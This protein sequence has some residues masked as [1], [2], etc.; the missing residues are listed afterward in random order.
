M[1]HLLLSAAIAALAAMAIAQSTDQASQPQGREGGKGEPPPRPL[2][3]P[4]GP[5]PCF[6][7]SDN[8]V[9]Q[10]GAKCPVFGLA[11]PGAEVTVSFAGQSASAKAGADGRWRVVLEPMEPSA[12]GREMKI[13]SAGR[14]VS[15]RNVRVGDVWL[16]FGQSNMDL[17]FDS[18]FSNPKDA[19]SDDAAGLW[20]MQPGTNKSG[21]PVLD[22][23]RTTSWPAQEHRVTNEWKPATAENARLFSM[24][25]YYFGRQ[26]AREQGVP[27]GMINVAVGTTVIGQWCSADADAE[28]RGSKAKPVTTTRYA[29][30][31]YEGKKGPICYNGLI[32]PLQGMALRGMLFYQG[33]SEAAWFF[34]ANYDKWF[35]AMI[36]DLRAKWG[37]GD[38]PLLFVQIQSGTGKNDAAIREMQTR[39]LGQPNTAMIVCADVCR[40]LHPANKQQVAERLV[41]AARV[42]AYDQKGEYMG[43]VFK[44]M[45]VQGG[46]AR[47]SFDHAGGGLIAKDGKPLGV[48][49]AEP[50]DVSSRSAPPAFLIA[51]ADGRFFA[52]A[53]EI[54]GDA[55]VVSNPS[56]PVPAAVRYAWHVNPAMTLYN[57]EGLP[58]SPF[59]TDADKPLD[60]KPPASKPAS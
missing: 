37:M 44:E 8:C 39:G 5:V 12:Q 38:L 23:H 2:A 48:A 18:K 3:L 49:A 56:V 43:P 25:G 14:S 30:D 31:A 59:R 50:Y 17:P 19:P 34:N 26:T 35:T 4:D 45:K 7:F 40:G 6:V 28:A 22:I 55:V 27:V 10:R 47:I 16:C 53:A 21:V 11:E 32:H 57:K 42:L 1:K 9:L 60:A 54:E 33:E 13:G 24:I 36:K 41:A 29:D 52:A 51:G 20:L 58:A 46:R 15:V